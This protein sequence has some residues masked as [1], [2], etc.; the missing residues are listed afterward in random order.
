MRVLLGRPILDIIIW[1][2]LYTGTKQEVRNLVYATTV[3]EPYKQLKVETFVEGRGWIEVP[4]VLEEM[5]NGNR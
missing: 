1:R 3:V 2:V 4:D 5:K